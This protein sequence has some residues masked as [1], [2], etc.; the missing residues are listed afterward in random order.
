MADFPCPP[1]PS[2]TAALDFTPQPPVRWFQPGEL[3]RAGV[4]A[5]LGDLFGSYADKREIQAALRPRPSQPEFD[6]AADGDELWLDF[7]ADIGDGFD[8]TYTIARLLAEPTLSLGG[9]ETQRGRILIMGGDEVYPTATRRQY[10]DRSAGP[11]R[12]ALPCADP[13][14]Y[15]HL[16]ALPGNHDWYDGLTSFLRLFAQDRWIGGWKTRQSRSYFAV[17]LPQRY[18]LW[19]I[20][21]QLQ[22][23]MDDPQRL[24]F[25]EAAAKLEAGDRVILCTAEPSW[26]RSAEGEPDGYRNLAFLQERMI[27]PRG[28]EAVLMLTGDSH[29]YARYQRE[30]GGQMLV[31]A[32]GGGAFLHGTHTLPQRLELERQPW[33]PGSKTETFACEGRFPGARASRQAAWKIWRFPL[34]NWNFALMLGAFWLLLAWTLQSASLRGT[35]SFLEALL[36]HPDD[37]WPILRAFVEPAIYSPISVLLV[38][39]FGAGCI[40]FCKARKPL[41]KIAVGTLHACVQL[42]AWLL[43]VWALVHLNVHQLGV[44]LTSWTIIFLSIA[45]ML[46]I[47]S[48]VSGFLFGAYLAIASHFV[49]AHFDDIFSALGIEDAKNFLRLHIDREGRLT[50]YAVGVKDVAHDWRLAPAAAPDAPWFES[51]SRK[52]VA[53]LAKLIEKPIAIPR[54]GGWSSG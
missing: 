49:P 46:L 50:V 15:P 48:F 44:E 34:L 21:I 35:R 28:A 7:V 42:A 6:Y 10:Q 13:A 38:T 9:H 37:V 19:G 29:H 31:T 26:V 1:R 45:E 30:D 11:Y 40:G 18:W 8:A 41:F 39:V 16:F 43:L 12:A 47:G 27:R 33:S 5:V 54:G 22:A 32:G 51:A 24:Y 23:D 3:V 25:M 36:D 14:R 17:R 4:R 20:D 52:N 2:T 53:T